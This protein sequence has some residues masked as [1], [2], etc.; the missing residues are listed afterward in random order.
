MISKKGTLKNNLFQAP[1]NHSKKIYMP[2]QKCIKKTGKYI[3]KKFKYHKTM[4]SSLRCNQDYRV[5]I[6]AAKPVNIIRIM[7]PVIFTGT[8]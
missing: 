5:C 7:L 1:I 2:F 3:K 4:N 8:N 6:V